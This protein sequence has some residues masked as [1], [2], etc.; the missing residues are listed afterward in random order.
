MVWVTF[1]S[2][3]VGMV[4]RMT[5][6]TATVMLLQCGQFPLIRPSMMDKTPI[7]TNLVLLH[8]LPLL[9]TE[10]KIPTRVS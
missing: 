2:G 1:M 9:A 8:L 6:V 4:G 5:T 10:L 7:T 3:Q